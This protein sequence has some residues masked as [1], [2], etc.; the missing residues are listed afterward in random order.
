MKITKRNNTCLD[1]FSFT[2]DCVDYV[3]EINRYTNNW[4][5]ADFLLRDITHGESYD[6]HGRIEVNGHVFT[7]IYNTNEPRDRYFYTSSNTITVLVDE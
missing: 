2:Y 5:Y 3:I 6:A 7:V 4:T 1:N